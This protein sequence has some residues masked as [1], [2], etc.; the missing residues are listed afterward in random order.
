MHL[1]SS[2]SFVKST[3]TPWKSYRITYGF[4]LCDEIYV[5]EH[6]FNKKHVINCQTDYNWEYL[7]FTFLLIHE[8]VIYGVLVLCQT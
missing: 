1:L 4:S 5:S 3:M 2:Q 7:I 8:Y 6:K